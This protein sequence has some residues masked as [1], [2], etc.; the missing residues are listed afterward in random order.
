MTTL[1]FRNCRPTELHPHW[2]QRLFDLDPFVVGD[3][4]IRNKR[5]V[6]RN[7][8]VAWRNYD[9]LGI[10]VCGNGK[11]VVKIMSKAAV[12]TALVMDNLPIII[13][14][15]CSPIVTLLRGMRTIALHAPDSRKNK[16]EVS[17]SS[18]G[19]VKLGTPLEGSKKWG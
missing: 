11:L 5:I 14:A 18:T 4:C 10:S 17:V 16:G 12:V 8:Y 6:T 19:R 9:I 13:G 15:S 1:G 3:H 7:Q 2:I